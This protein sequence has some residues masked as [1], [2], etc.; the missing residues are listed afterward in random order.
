MKIGND[1]M[2]AIYGTLSSKVCRECKHFAG[3]TCLLMD[4]REKVRVRTYELA[5][6]KFEGKGRKSC[7]E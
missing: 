1:A 2:R 4:G 7:T 5:C 6:Q 3:A